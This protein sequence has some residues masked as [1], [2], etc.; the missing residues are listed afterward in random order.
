MTDSDIRTAA[1][2]AAFAAR[3]EYLAMAE[4]R[5][6]A[7][8]AR[9]AAGTVR[10]EN[11]IWAEILEETGLA[12]EFRRLGREEQEAQ[13]LVRDTHDLAHPLDTPAGLLDDEE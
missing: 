9:R 1:D 10:D 8:E 5:A 7:R 13:E 12:E 3:M 11:A 6:Q 2:L 4:K